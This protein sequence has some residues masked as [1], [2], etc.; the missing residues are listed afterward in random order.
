MIS[1]IFVITDFLNNIMKTKIYNDTVKI[2]QMVFELSFAGSEETGKT[3]T[4]ETNVKLSCKEEFNVI[5][6]K[7]FGNQIMPYGLGNGYKII[8]TIH[9]FIVCGIGGRL[10]SLSPE[11]Q[12]IK[13]V[14]ISN[15]A[16]SNI[17]IRK[18]KIF[19]LCEDYEFDL[20]KY[21][22]NLSCYNDK[23]E[24]I[25]Y[26]QLPSPTDIYT[27]TNTSIKKDLIAYTWESWRCFL[28]METG[29]II[30]KNFTK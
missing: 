19:I 5:W 27:E 26:A 16:I 11:G 3:T 23:L 4:E 14:K 15:T 20:E 7:D 25:W 9:N 18:N 30:R 21:I 1:N 12:I 2:N 29:K 17:L 13:D 22:S 28:N 6:T 8:G 24:N 10:I